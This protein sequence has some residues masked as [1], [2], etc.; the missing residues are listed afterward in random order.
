MWA[1]FY[2]VKYD[3]QTVK[4]LTLVDITQ[5][6]ARRGDEQKKVQQQANFMTFTQTA[7]LRVNPMPL[8]VVSKTENIDKLGFGT[9]HSGKQRYWEYTFEHEYFGGL[10]KEMLL[11]D[12][13]L[14]PVLTGLDETSLINN[15][16]VRTRNDN[17]RNI[18]FKL[19][20]NEEQTL[21]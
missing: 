1:F 6:M 17:D 3:M 19:L 2:G 9:N 10:T 20:D 12:F 16:V 7:G 15:N 5:T 18:V 14:I 4:I 8:T 13:D 11:D 21:E